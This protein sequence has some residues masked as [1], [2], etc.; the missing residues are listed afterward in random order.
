MAVW[1]C[2]WP[3]C[4]PGR[5]EAQGLNNSGRLIVCRTCRSTIPTVDRPTQRTSVRST[6]ISKG[7]A[8]WLVWHRKCQISGVGRN[9][10]PVRGLLTKHHWVVG[11]YRNAETYDRGLA[12]TCDVTW[13]MNMENQP[14]QPMNAL[15]VHEFDVRI[16]DARDLVVSDVPLRAPASATTESWIF[17]M[18]PRGSS[19]PE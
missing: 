4:K 13:R 6:L 7:L 19:I 9:G 17:E 15:N 10:L 14:L 3:E 2:Q 11:P 16:F 8:D 1:P 18:D 12:R 5:G